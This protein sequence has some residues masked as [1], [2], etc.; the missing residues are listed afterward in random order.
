MKKE[1]FV[2]RHIGPSEE[3]VQEMMKVVNV[4]SLEQLIEEIVPQDIMVEKCVFDEEPLTE[5]ELYAKMKELGAKNKCFKNYIGQGYY[6]TVTPSPI[7][8]HILED[9]TWYTSYTPYQAEISQ[10]RLEALL[11]F[12]TMLIDL[13]SMPLANCSLLDEATATHEAIFMMHGLR[14]A[15]QK[16]AGA[17]KVFVDKNTFVQ[18]LDVVKGRAE[19]LNY[20]LVIGDYKSV[21][22]D[23]SYFGAVVQYPSADGSIADYHN[24]AKQLQE[25]GI[26]FTVI[27]DV[28]SLVLLTPPGEWGADIVVGSTQRFGIPMGYGGPH[29][30]FLACRE[31]YK[32]S[33]PGRIIGVTQNAEGKK[34]LRMALQTREQH[35]KRERATSNIC[36]AQAL[37]ATM[38][39]FYT[40]YHGKEGLLRIATNI[41]TNT[42]TLA[43]ALEQMS[44]T[45]NSEIYF[46]T[47]ELNTS[48]E[49]LEK[50]K[51]N[52]LQEEINLNYVD[53]ETIRIS[54]GENIM[55][56]DLEK[57][58]AV[59]AKALDVDSPTLKF[60][61]TVSLPKE[62]LRTT[63][64]LKANVFN[65]HHSET[66]LM[67]YIKKLERKDLGLNTAMI[68]LGSCTMKLNSATSMFPL[69]WTEFNSLHPFAPCDQAK[70]YSEM[71]TEL[72]NML[73]RIT[74]FADT[75]LQ[76]NSGASGEHSGLLVIRKHHIS[77]GEGHR[78]I[79]L[80]PRSAHGTNP[81]SAVV[82]GYKPIIVKSDDK[83]NVDV[84]DLKVQAEKYKDNLAA[85][86][87]T[88]PSTHGIFETSIREICDTIHKYGGQVY[89]DGANMNGQSG[90]TNPGFIGADV[91]HLNLHKSFAIPHGGGGPGIGS[92]G[93]AEHLVKHLPNHTMKKVGGSEGIN[94]VAAAPYGSASVATIT[95]AYLKMIGNNLDYTT[96]I[97]L[98][99][100]NYIA[101]KLEENGMKILYKG[102][103]G[104][105]GHELI[106]DCNEFSK[107][108][109]ITDLDI[110]KR[111]MDFGF[112]APTLSFPVHGTLMI[113]PT[114][115]EP[116]EELDRFIEALIIIKK[117]IEEV[118]SGLYP[119]DDNVL[120]NAPHTQT[121]LLADEWTHSY[122]R[123]KAAY[124][125]EYLKE[126]K[127][128]PATAR[129][130]DGFGDRNLMCSCLDLE[131]YVI[132]E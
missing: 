121:M 7:I 102:H 74:G 101:T 51:K 2:K 114:E 100:S 29:A 129:V 56:K 43:E 12:Q 14:N 4:N 44:I 16:K 20:E 79:V 118:Q 66:A 81:A 96:K 22:L 131:N 76:P 106:F 113:E 50:I 39:G 36:T 130:D 91:C 80:I 42:R 17:N 57:L 31:E 26:K 32:R 107:N 47:L 104:R 90:L 128:W 94:A 132:Q 53:A 67:R 25:K 54:M 34:A 1:L 83:G 6:E 63:D 18:T 123:T 93:V 95:Y 49:L 119:S 112:H 99:S 21:Q 78:D 60:Y 40:V 108:A 59:F 46:D 61:D 88:Y 3:D 111:L 37:L 64:F 71:L 45:V 69:S 125:V 105:V 35:I 86:M 5:S 10:G 15:T 27:A 68:P 126:N 109:G 62:L 122:S 84:E 48:A 52:A 13:T 116:K 75:S 120:K 70:G 117:E 92:I 33:V 19:A 38:A 103:K 115:S 87:I 65:A 41:Q 98:L 8:R 24:F 82:V 127:F 124:P 23:E 85:I 73:S 55:P 72:E 97:G 77:N 110:A 11:N 30:G 58:V 28:M 89:M 9:A